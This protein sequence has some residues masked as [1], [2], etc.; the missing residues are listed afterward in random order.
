MATLTATPEHPILMNA[1][2][3]RAAI[4]GEKTQTRRILKPQ[5]DFIGKAGEPFW[6]PD[7][8]RCVEIRCPF[9][10]RGDRLWVRE[11]WGCKECREYDPSGVFSMPTGECEIVYRAGGENGYGTPT[12]D[13]WRPSIHMPRWASRLTLE[14]TDV[15][16]ERLQEITEADAKAEGALAWLSSLDGRAYDEA[17]KAWCR[18]SKRLNPNATTASAL[19]AFATL[20]E[21]I[22]GPGSWEADP[23]VWVV[24]FRRIEHN[25][26]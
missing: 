16:H 13:R 26:N 8:G 4:A 21:R 6:K 12:D 5:P 17:E 10:S 9:G 19:G 18:W 23:F 11:T 15:R 25:G 20:W 22:Y 1:P 24:N 2:M 14:I 7:P 3:V